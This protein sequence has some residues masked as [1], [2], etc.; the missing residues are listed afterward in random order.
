MATYTLSKTSTTVNEGSN[1]TII[2]DTVGVPN[3]T[4]VPFTIT[5]TGVDTDDFISTS[6]TG[7]FNV[8]SNQGRITLDLKK[9][10]N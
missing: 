9:D 4:L 8:R 5:G 1:V 6:L 3:N 10:F 2:L 7:N